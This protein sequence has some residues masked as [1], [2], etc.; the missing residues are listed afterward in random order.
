M[1]AANAVPAAIKSNDKLKKKE[2]NGL[3]CK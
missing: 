2:K 1:L 3:G